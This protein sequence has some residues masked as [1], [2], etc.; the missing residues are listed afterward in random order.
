[1]RGSCGLLL[2]TAFPSTHAPPTQRREQWTWRL[3]RGSCGL[4]LIT[5][6]LPPSLS[7]SHTETRAVDVADH[8]RELRPAEAIWDACADL[9]GLPRGV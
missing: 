7:P 3:M 2:I 6:S 1:M 9:A 4:L 5:A 8:A